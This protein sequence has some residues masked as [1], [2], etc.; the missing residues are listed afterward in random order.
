M[1][2]SIA[3]LGIALRQAMCLCGVNKMVVNVMV[4]YR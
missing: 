1:Y 2:V 4:L 3:E